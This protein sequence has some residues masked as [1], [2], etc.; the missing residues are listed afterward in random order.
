M[1][2][3]ASAHLWP[4]STFPGWRTPIR[5]P[6]PAIV[7]MLTL[8][9]TLTQARLRAAW[10]AGPPHLPEQS[11]ELF[12]VATLITL[13]RP[14]QFNPSRVL[15]SSRWPI[16][17]WCTHSIPQPHPSLS[18]VADELAVHPEQ[19]RTY[20]NN[21]RPAKPLKR[22]PCARAADVCSTGADGHAIAG[23]GHVIAP[24][25]H[26]IADDEHAYRA[27]ALPLHAGAVDSDHYGTPVAH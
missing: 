8:T 18:Q 13:A 14:P 16:R 3:C 21:R 22:K 26:A 25:G 6:T 20:A 10:N 17:S 9:P 1:V 23:D 11:T 2:E 12:R 4:E 7:R 15:S 19:L 27:H 5:T 24:D